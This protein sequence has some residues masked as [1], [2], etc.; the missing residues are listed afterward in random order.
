MGQLLFNAFHLFY[1]QA[2][3]NLSESSLA[4]FESF[5]QFTCFYLFR[6]ERRSFWVMT[7]LA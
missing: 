2:P 4:A 5:Y 6:L 3:Q 1:S 7:P